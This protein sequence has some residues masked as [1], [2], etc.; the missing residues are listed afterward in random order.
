MCL[1]SVKRW[2]CGVGIDIDPPEEKEDI[3]N[4]EVYTIL[5]A[6]FGKECKLYLS[7]REYKT[8]TVDELK[9]FLSN[10]IVD[11]YKYISEYYDCDDFSFALMGNMS[12]PEWSDLTFGILWSGTPNGG[13]A[14]NCFIDI[15]REVWI[16]EPQ[17]DNVF[18]LPDDWTPWVVMM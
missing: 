17:N 16:I 5:Q 6:E 1:D 15:D 12:V 3:G 10:D 14:I 9:R 18:K 4:S 11:S 13:H 2:I 7:D 8:T